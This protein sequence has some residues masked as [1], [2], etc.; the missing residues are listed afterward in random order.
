MSYGIT[1]TWGCPWV[2][3]HFHC[4]FTGK[5]ANLHPNQLELL[6]CLHDAL[7]IRHALKCILDST[8]YFLSWIHRI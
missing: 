1:L 5:L 3:R 4:H 7:D 8:K 2:H 6:Q